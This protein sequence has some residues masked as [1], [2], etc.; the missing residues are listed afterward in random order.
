[1]SRIRDQG[2]DS[3]K[4]MMRALGLTAMGLGLPLALLGGPTAKLVRVL[5]GSRWAAMDLVIP[6]MCVAFLII[7]PISVAMAGRLFA[8]GKVR[9]V[10]MSGVAH[11]LVVLA[12][13]AALFTR[14]RL[15]AV[16]VGHIASASVEAVVFVTALDIQWREVIAQQR[17][18]HHVAAAPGDNSRVGWG[19]D[20]LI[21]LIA[22]ESAVTAIYVALLYAVGPSDFRRAVNM[23]R[24]T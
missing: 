15:A 20:D 4:A 12:V 13:T 11:T 17:A 14:L 10:V 16:G 8:L 1:M 22:A 24:G 23:A 21:G 18:D 7:G 6:L 9:I 3:G 2:E 5:F 19:T